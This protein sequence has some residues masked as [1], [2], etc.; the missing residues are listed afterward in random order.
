VL[1]FSKTA[2]FRHDSIPDAI[3]ALE[4]QGQMRGWTVS[5]TE[6]GA[7]FVSLDAFDVVVFLL[8]TGDVLDDAQQASFEGFIQAGGGYV[9]V[10]SASDTEYG[11]PWYG[12]LVGAY[13]AGHPAI[14]P[15]TLV[16]EDATH[17]T[18]VGLPASWMRT[19]EWYSFDHNPRDEVNVLVSIDEASYDPGNLAMGDHPVAWWHEYDGGRSFYTALGHTSESYTEPEFVAHLSAAIEWAGGG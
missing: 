3:A 7:Q 18:T 2:G 15:A 9:G 14:Q 6:D 12:A 8:T 5:A 13:F 19:D 10:H 11:W 4:T 16:V 1:L 17:P